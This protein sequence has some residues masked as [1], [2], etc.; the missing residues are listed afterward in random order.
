MQ[1]SVV[2]DTEHH[3]FFNL[4]LPDFCNFRTFKITV[5]LSKFNN[6]QCIFAVLVFNQ[7]LKAPSP[8]SLPL[9][10]KTNR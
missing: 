3:V 1:K 2:R 6:K 9:R 8:L 4:Y 7:H 5:I 10:F